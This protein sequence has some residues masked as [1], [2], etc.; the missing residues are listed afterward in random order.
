MSPVIEEIVDLTMSSSTSRK[1]RLNLKY[2]Q[3]TRRITSEWKRWRVYIEAFIA[4]A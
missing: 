2:I 1:L 4:I 3:T